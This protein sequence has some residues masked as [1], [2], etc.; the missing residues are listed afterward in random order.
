VLRT[1]VLVDSDGRVLDAWYGV[2]PRDTA[3]KAA[4]AI[5]LA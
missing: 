4:L 5:P 2:R 3:V 1:A